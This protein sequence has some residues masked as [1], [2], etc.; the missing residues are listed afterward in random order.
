[1]KLSARNHLVGQ[2]EELKLG[3]IL[4]HAVVR[5]GNPQKI[6]DASALAAKNVRIVNREKGSGVATET[7]QDRDE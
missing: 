7:T 5:R 3:D 2:V 4:A 6:H 1:V